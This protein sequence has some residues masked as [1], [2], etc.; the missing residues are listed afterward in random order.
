[1]KRTS[2]LKFDVSSILQRAKLLPKPKVKGISIN[3]PFLSID[4][5]V[6]DDIRKIAREVL[7]RLRDKRVLVAWECCDNCV[8]NALTSI[9]DIRT[10]LVNKQ[11][12]LSDDDSALFLLFDLMLA[13]IRQFLTYTER[14]DPHI[15]RE[16]YFG[17]LEVLRGHLLRCIE[18]IAKVGNVSPQLSNRFNF[19]PI[20]EKEIYVVESPPSDNSK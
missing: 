17:A 20:W 10:L 5:R 13:G 11:V 4:L 19:N 3:L 9:Q 14:Y 8:R 6:S 7:I 15:H 12:E 2:E 1:M 16:E 18:E